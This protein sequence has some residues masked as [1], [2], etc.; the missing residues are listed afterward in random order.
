[1]H[2]QCGDEVVIGGTPTEIEFELQ[3]IIGAPNNCGIC[4]SRF[5]VLPAGAPLKATSQDHL[6][7]VSFESSVEEPIYFHISSSHFDFNSSYSV[8]MNWVPRPRA[9]KE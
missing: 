4:K 1:M 8:E 5:V 7:E 9:P 6:M 2:A 3:L